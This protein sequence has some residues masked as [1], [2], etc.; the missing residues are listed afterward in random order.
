VRNITLQI[1]H[2]KDVHVEPG[3]ASTRWTFEHQLFA[4]TVELGSLPFGQRDRTVEARCPYCALEPRSPSLFLTL[5]ERTV[6]R[7]QQDGYTPEVL[8]RLRRHVIGSFIPDMAVRAIAGVALLYVFLWVALARL[9]P[10]LSD[11][12]RPFRDVQG[13]L[14]LLVFAGVLG[15]FA[16]VLLK[17]SQSR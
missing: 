5:S 13:A 1:G 10:L 11:S 4:L 14:V 8:A 17:N 12:S 2:E 15:V 3:I 7:L 6:V 16:F 9:F